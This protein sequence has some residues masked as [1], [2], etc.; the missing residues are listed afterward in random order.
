MKSSVHP[1]PLLLFLS[2]ILLILSYW[3]FGYAGALI[4]LVS[5]VVFGGAMGWL[6]G[7]KWRM[8][9]WQIGIVAAIPPTLFVLW[10]FLTAVT[11]EDT[12]RN[13]STFIFHPL[14]VLIGAHFG[15][16]MG[17]W[18]ALKAKSRGT[19]NDGD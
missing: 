14:L 8:Y 7:R 4:F 9:P 11:P 15:G 3:L 12:S 6:V 17:R 13:V 18:Q 19:P 16:L 2:V 5:A 10:L 1:V